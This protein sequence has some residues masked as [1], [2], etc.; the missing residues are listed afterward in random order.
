MSSEL[1]RQR[2]DLINTQ[3][4][5]IDS[6][7]SLGV[8]KEVLVDID[9]REVVALGLRDNI[10]AVPGNLARYM[11]LSSI[12]KL[13]DSILVDTDDVIE[14]IDPEA[15]TSLVN[16][17]VITETGDVLG[18]VRGFKFS[19]EDGRL[20][21]II[22]AA[23]GLPLIPDQV[24][25]TYELSIDEVVSSGPNRLIVI[26]GTEERL[27]QLSVGFLERIGLGKA[28]WEDEY[29]DYRPTVIR[30]E[31]QLPAGLPVAAPPPM[32]Q[33]VR[34]PQPSPLER[35]SAIAETTWEEDDWHEPAPPSPPTLLKA[36]VVRYEDDE[37]EGNWS[38]TSRD[39]RR[40]S[41]R[42][43][44]PARP[45]T[46]KFTD[47]DGEDDIIDVWEDKVPDRFKP[48]EQNDPPGAAAVPAAPKPKAPNGGAEVLVDLDP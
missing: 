35:T 6:A 44:P 25:S 5:T 36:E 21:S 20:T 14:D 18:K 30:P 34:I 47:V 27:E 31:N 3:V 42:P 33:Q 37:E 12:R 38:D 48:P 16:C 41:R 45:V 13:G 26:E 7:K 29:G 19:C 24:I 17:E 39:S 8:V 28:P 15:Y 46:P 9:S 10:V 2:S 4:I 11:L 1:I 22:I 40:P 32:R 23:V 43:D